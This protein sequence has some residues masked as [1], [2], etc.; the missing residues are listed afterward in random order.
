VK[1]V[2]DTWWLLWAAGA[3]MVAGLVL[4]TA[5]A[6]DVTAFKVGAGAFALAMVVVER[7]SEHKEAPG[8]TQLKVG[9]AAAAFGLLLAPTKD[10]QGLGAL[11]GVVGGFAIAGLVIA[12]IE[13]KAQGKKP[14][15]G[16]DEAP[17]AELSENGGVTPPE[18]G[19][20]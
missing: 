4:G 11:L 16:A 10:S 3:G 17:A 1:A 14:V 7:T 12:A 13:P 2:K 8:F 20:A 18:G 5:G 6:A 19:G 9:L 15:S